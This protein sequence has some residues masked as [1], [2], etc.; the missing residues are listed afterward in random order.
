MEKILFKLLKFRKKFSDSYGKISK[1]RKK[2]PE[3]GKNNIPETVEKH[4]KLGINSC[5]IEKNSKKLK[6][7]LESK[8]KILEGFGN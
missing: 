4:L 1:D 5:S 8:E 3:P 6:K 7:F 2:F